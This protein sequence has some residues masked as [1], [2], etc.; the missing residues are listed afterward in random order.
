MSKKFGAFQYDRND[1]QIVGEKWFDT[2]AERDRFVENHQSGTSSAVWRKT[3]NE[4]E[5]DKAKA[6][7]EDA[8]DPF[9]SFDTPSGTKMMRVSEGKAKGYPHRWWK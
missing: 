3:H 6:K 8:K 9:K 2:K 7:A 4:H 1:G 5:A